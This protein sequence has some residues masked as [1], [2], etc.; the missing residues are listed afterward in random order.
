MDLNRD[1][2]RKLEAA[3]PKYTP[4]SVEIV[5]GEIVVGTKGNNCQQYRIQ[6]LPEMTGPHIV[7]HFLVSGGSGNDI[8]S[9][10]TSEDEFPNWINGHEAKLFYSTNGSKTTDRFDVA[11]DAGNYM[12]GFCRPSGWFVAPRNVALE[13]KLNY[14]RLVSQ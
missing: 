12:L 7:G 10:L 4:A 8:T 14:D 13:V 5:S 6:V 3:Q 11:L 9:A 2:V 1:L